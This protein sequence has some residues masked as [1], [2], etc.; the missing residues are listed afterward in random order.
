MV[1]VAL[2]PNTYTDAEQFLQLAGVEAYT[3]FPDLAGLPEGFHEGT[4][5]ILRYAS[6]RYPEL[7]D[8]A[9]L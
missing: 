5:D 9:G 8:D 7:L 2:H 3:Y 6:Q 1:K 4:E